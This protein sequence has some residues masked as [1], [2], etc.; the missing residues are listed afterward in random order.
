MDRFTP[1]GVGTTLYSAGDSLLQLVHPHGRG[2]NTKNT[3]C[4]NSS[5]AQSFV[6]GTAVFPTYRPA[7]GG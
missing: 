7:A 4:F 3:F 2:D 5:I 1:T 6:Q